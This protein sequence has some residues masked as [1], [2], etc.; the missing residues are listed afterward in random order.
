LYFRKTKDKILNKKG[1]K[2][3]KKDFL[4]IINRAK[5]PKCKKNV[6]FAEANGLKKAFAKKRKFLQILKPEEIQI[7][8]GF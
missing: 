3:K 1:K 5:T 7:N 8:S 6:N 2:N 4:N